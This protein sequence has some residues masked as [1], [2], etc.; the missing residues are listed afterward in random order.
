VQES[1]KRFMENKMREN[2]DL[3]GT[4]IEIYFRQK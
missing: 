1:Y 3:T 2:F 4:P